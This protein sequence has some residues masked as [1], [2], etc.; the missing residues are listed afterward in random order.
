MTILV[1][2][3]AGFIGSHVAERLALAGHD[4]LP[5]DALVPNYD[6]AIKRAN[7]RD[8]ASAAPSLAR[9]EPVD[10]RDE[11]AV[12]DVIERAR[13]DLVIHCA[14]LAGVRPSVERPRAYTEHNVIGTIN[15]LEAMRK[16]GCRKLVFASSSSVYGAD[17]VAPFTE[18]Q[19]AVRP[20]SPY[21]ASKRACELFLH[22]YGSLYGLDFLSLRFFTVYGPRQRPDLAIHKFTS[23][24]M[25]GE[26]IPVNGDGRSSRDYTHIDDI[27][28]GVAAAARLLL[29]ESGARET[30]NLGSSAPVLLR[31][32]IALIETACDREAIIDRRP[33]QPGDVPRTFADVS[34]AR[35]MLGYEVTR[36]LGSGIREFVAWWQERFVPA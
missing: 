32:L 5:L 11:R 6:P 33:N 13:P 12:A 35:R 4:V 28:A 20:A 22:T 16:A 26:P 15:L 3:A 29:R 27:A 14:A 2:G 8:M 17:A 36:E 30:I 9:L 1:T 25:R 23:A 31:E 7:I 34:K 10:L 18:D 21:A 24:I 19:A